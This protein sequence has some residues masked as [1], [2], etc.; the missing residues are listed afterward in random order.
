MNINSKY[1]LVG[2]ALLFVNVAQAGITLGGTR[3]VLQEKNKEVSILVKNDGAE[4]IM[5]Q[6]WVE[7]NDQQKLDDVPFAL[8]PA[9]S[10]LA[11]G[12]Q[13]S[14]RIFYFGRG[15]AADKESVFWLNVQEIPQKAKVDNTLQI[16]LRQRIKVFYRPAEL[17]G[18]VQ[19]SIKALRWKWVSGQGKQYVQV[20][21]P[22]VY[23]VSFST[24]HVSVGGK[25]YP[26]STE[27][28][29]P[30]TTTKFPI[31]STSAITG[32]EATL[33]FLTIND[34][35]APVEN[36]VSLSE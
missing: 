2:I 19:D 20:T 14:L 32:T 15:L 12:K 21:N 8:T 18:T 10:R 22:S 3:L 1:W 24:A 29:L 28:V 13:Q 26:V 36:I 31:T 27:M 6:S 35:G 7:S 9:L 30:G 5:I 34:Y 25:R 11:A 4:D 23:H 16:A 17:T 33:V